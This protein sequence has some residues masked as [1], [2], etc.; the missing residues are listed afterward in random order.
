MSK[1][2][3]HTIF[4]RPMSYFH[5]FADIDA[6]GGKKCCFQSEHC[7]V[8]SRPKCIWKVDWPTTTHHSPPQHNTQLDSGDNVQL[9]I[10]CWPQTVQCNRTK[11]SFLKHNIGGL[12]PFG[13]L[14]L[15]PPNCTLQTMCNWSHPICQYNC[16]LLTHSNAIVLPGETRTCYHILKDIRDLKA[17]MTFTI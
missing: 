10:P 1:C 6:R 3:P 17:R 7:K 8:H 9:A 11:I 12:N 16:R 14:K 15:A 2:N 5:A 4:V 13:K